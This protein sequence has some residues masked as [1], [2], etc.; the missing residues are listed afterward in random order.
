MCILHSSQKHL[1]V[2]R[3]F[4]QFHCCG[5][6]GPGDY[7]RKLIPKSCCGYAECDAS[8]V[9]VSQLFIALSIDS[10]TLGCTG[11]VKFISLYM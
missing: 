11:S 3:L 9:P 1:I 10:H 8:T 6:M 2:I 7:G 5:Y 4:F